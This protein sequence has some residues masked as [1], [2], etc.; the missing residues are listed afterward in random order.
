[1][2]TPNEPP[3]GFLFV[4]FL[5]KDHTVSRVRQYGRGAGIRNALT[6]TLATLAI[7]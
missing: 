5:R 4:F 3:H 7:Q 2:H 6:D 1:M